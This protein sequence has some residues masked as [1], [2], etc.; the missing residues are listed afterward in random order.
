MT[1]PL[2]QEL[3]KRLVQAVEE[4]ASAREAAAWFAVSAS[5]GWETMDDVRTL[6]PKRLTL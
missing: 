2:S 4:G 6:L 5:L 1:A 3:H